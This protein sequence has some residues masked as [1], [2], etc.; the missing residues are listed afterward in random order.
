MLL[1]TDL[2][3]GLPSYGKKEE[4]LDVDRADRK[5]KLGLLVF[6]LF[7][8]I[9]VLAMSYVE[10]AEQKKVCSNFNTSGAQSEPEGFLGKLKASCAAQCEEEHN[11]FQGGCL[12]SWFGEALHAAT[13]QVEAWLRGGN[14]NKSEV[15]K[16]DTKPKRPCVKGGVAPQIWKDVARE[17]GRGFHGDWEGVLFSVVV[18]FMGEQGLDYVKWMTAVAGFVLRK[19]EGEIRADAINHD[20]FEALVEPAVL[21][22][23]RVASH[24]MTSGLVLG[25][26]HLRCY[27]D[28]L[29]L[30]KFKIDTPRTGG[31][32]GLLERVMKVTENGDPFLCA[33]VEDFQKWAKCDEEDACSLM[34]SQI[35]YP[36]MS[37]LGCVWAAGGHSPPDTVTAHVW[38]RLFGC[39]EHHVLPALGLTVCKAVGQVLAKES[40]KSFTSSE[41][42]TAFEEITSSEESEKSPLPE[43]S[44]KSASEVVA[45]W[46]EDSHLCEALAADVL[47]CGKSIEE[48]RRLCSSDLDED[49]SYRC[50]CN[51]WSW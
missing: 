41:A 3:Q 13:T 49:T 50:T 18:R 19:V 46:C 36:I 24:R 48:A 35:L 5:W 21:E 7:V 47:L 11:V 12:P 28:L 30:E 1:N 20:S 39:R 22:M 16:H 51:L 26:P 29:D 23:A 42:I 17:K 27:R 37:S 32:E 8:A 40:E 25:L 10:S 45:A 4:L 14:G 38:K 43:K 6:G 33:I 9:L 2:E 34:V 31:P 15:R 44:F